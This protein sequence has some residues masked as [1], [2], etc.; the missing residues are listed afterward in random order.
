MLSNLSVLIK[1]FDWGTVPDWVGALGTI[2]AVAAVALQINSEHRWST[3]KKKEN[4]RPLFVVLN[5]FMIPQNATIWSSFSRIDDT[6]FDWTEV[7]LVNNNFARDVFVDIRGKI[8]KLKSDGNSYEYVNERRLISIPGIDASAILLDTHDMLVDN[9]IMFY[10]TPANEFNEMVLTQ[11]GHVFRTPE[12]FNST[13]DC[14]VKQKYYAYKNEV[15]HLGSLKLGTRMSDGTVVG[16]YVVT[17]DDKFFNDRQFMK[18]FNDKVKR[19]N[20]MLKL[21]REYN[22]L[23]SP[24]DK[25][26]SDKKRK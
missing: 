1:K 26:T 3:K 9:I 12:Y 11:K 23:N 17:A 16:S 21:Y 22:N 4:S 14:K 7:Q 24:S 19:N 20:K 25:G 10:K 13:D 6:G 8:S 15:E 18:Q 5:K 2:A